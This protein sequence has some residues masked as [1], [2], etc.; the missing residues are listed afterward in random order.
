MA[1]DGAN[2]LADLNHLERRIV[3][4]VVHIKALTETPFVE[5]GLE[6]LEQGLRVITEKELAVADD[7]AGVVEKYDKLGLSLA[8]CVLHVGA[9]HGVGLPEL[10]G[11]RFGE[12][13]PALALDIGVG[14]EQFVRFDDTSKRVGSK[15]LALQQA[16]LDAGAV[17]IG[18]VVAAAKG[19]AHLFDGFEHLLRSHFACFA[20][21]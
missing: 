14:F 3:A 21:V 5:C 10:V 9:D 4:A 18:D 11:V 15:A 2:A 7:A 1:Q 17:D 8:S 20:F 12:G 6:G 13:Q 19:G 16:T